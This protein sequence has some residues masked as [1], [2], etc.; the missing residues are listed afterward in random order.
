M[1]IQTTFPRPTVVG[2]ILAAATLVALLMAPALASSIDSFINPSTSNVEV[3]DSVLLSGDYE[4]RHVIDLGQG[5]YETT[6]LT[7]NGDDELEPRIVIES[8]GTV[9]IVYWRDLTTPDALVVSYDPV[10]ESWSAE[11]TLNGSAGG[12]A[13]ELAYDGTDSWFVFETGESAGSSVD[14]GIIA[15]EP[16]PINTVRLGTNDGSTAADP[17]IVAESGSLWVTWVD[18]GTYVAWSE[19]DS[20]NDSWST[21]QLEDYSADDVSSARARIRDDVLGL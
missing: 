6:Y 13:P 18:D 5:N 9:R 7:A 12:K 20:A 1:R 10:A 16:D 8:D 11:R 17:I 14:V 4:I 21:A 15:E 2:Q 19:Y 3:V